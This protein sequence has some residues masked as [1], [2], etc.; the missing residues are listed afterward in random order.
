[1]RPTRHQSCH[2][3][4]AWSAASDGGGRRAERPRACRVAAGAIRRLPRC[5]APRAHLLAHVPCLKPGCRSP[6]APVAAQEAG[7]RAA[8]VGGALRARPRGARSGG[9][10]RRML[11]SAGACTKRQN[12][13]KRHSQLTRRVCRSASLDPGSEFVLKTVRCVRVVM[14]SARHCSTQVS[15][16]R[17]A[18]IRRQATATHSAQG[19]HSVSILR[20]VHCGGPRSQIIT[21]RS[22]DGGRWL[23]RL[24]RSI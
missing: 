3:A 21:R 1:M 11:E 7:V 10:R 14:Y 18:H 23:G 17:T 13:K 24:P 9:V 22:Q 15:G 8:G 5:A 19:L 16:S 12:A 6:L 2:S 20:G 4:A